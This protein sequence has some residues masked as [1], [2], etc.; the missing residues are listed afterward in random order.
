MQAAGIFVGA[1]A[2]FSARVQ[3]RQHQFDGG[4][5]PLRVH[6]HRN[7]SSVVFDRNAIIYMNRNINVFGVARQCFV[8]RVINDFVN[9]V[10]KTSNSGIANIHT[11]PLT[12]GL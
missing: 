9:T 1:L 7:A 4:H 3:I 8:N 11:G 12:N 5:F 10:V 6:V 2:E